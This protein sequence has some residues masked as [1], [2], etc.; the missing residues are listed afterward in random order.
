MSSDVR[1]FNVPSIASGSFDATM[2]WTSR[3]MT[4]NVA[5]RRVRA[6]F[7][8]L[9]VVLACVAQCA[10]HVECA[11]TDVA[12]DSGF[13]STLATNGLEEASRANANAD[14]DYGDDDEGDDGGGDDTEG[15][16]DDD[17]DDDDEVEEDYADDDYDY[18]YRASPS[19]FDEMR[20]KARDNFYAD[21]PA[22]T[23][24]GTLKDL[25]E[26]AKAS[27]ARNACA[28]SKVR[29][30]RK[31][32]CAHVRETEA[33][34]GRLQAYLS[35][36][37]CSGAWTFV[38]V[39][40]FAMAIAIAAYVLAVVA[41]VFFVPALETTATAMKLSPE[42]AGATLLS[43]GNGAPDLYA[44]IASLTEGTLP[45]LNLVVG[46]TL[47]SGLFIATAVLGAVVA[48]SPTAIVVHKE[49]FGQCAGMYALSIVFFM[50]ILCNGTLQLWHGVALTAAYI[51]Y[52]CLV[53][54]K[55]DTDTSVALSL[56]QGG[57]KG[58]KEDK[59]ARLEPLFDLASEKGG[60]DDNKG[61]VR[62]SR[63]KD[64][65]A[66]VTADMN[67]YEKRLSFIAVPT[68]VL[69]G[70]TMP[71]I[72]P[73]PLTKEYATVL[74]FF[75]PFFF[76]SAPG[77]AMFA[78]SSD[79]MTR[80]AYNAAFSLV[81]AFAVFGF[82]HVRYS[83]VPPP[84]A[85]GEIVAMLTF[86]QSL[87]WFHLASNELTMFVDALGKVLGINEEVLGVS[88]VAWGDSI[89]DF[90][91][92][93]A[94]AK[95]GRVSMAIT[96]CF[97]GPVFNLCIG[98]SSAIIFLTSVL[99]DVPFEVKQG[100]I[101]LCIASL[102]TVMLCVSMLQVKSPTEFEIPKKMGLI[103]AI[104]YFVFLALFLLCES[105]VLFGEAR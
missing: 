21:A 30:G 57:G 101:L 73:V 55:D 81:I 80:L 92:C 99:G 43:L 77:N 53:A 39:M 100:E 24:A 75:A 90:L 8:V 42:A 78:V 49:A 70:I 40:A 64:F 65:V 22:E 3:V 41:S 85:S 23:R 32:K 47:G 71:V 82:M 93:Y 89:G 68:R 60:P 4:T 91:S 59:T 36:A 58:K 96:A 74:G 103:L 6:S 1:N 10:R 2:H 87:S 31:A 76:L 54:F 37:Y 27:N 46:S 52:F 25:F 104:V 95:A 51:T 7:V 84:L 79:L 12:R 48:T 15:D 20:N 72:Q 19:A 26:H 35:A 38:P 29:G 66:S 28:P 61:A 33:C 67:A 63:H 98:V 34:E 17:D 62:V 102:L 45:D 18:V 69:M 83:N 11:T 5:L 94:V 56:E 50:I 97:A 105:R 86:L 9:V 44:Q 88:I 14:V 16:D 13:R